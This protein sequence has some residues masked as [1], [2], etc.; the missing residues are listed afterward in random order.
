MAHMKAQ[1]KPQIIQSV[2]YET[3]WERAKLF[4]TKM[5]P[6]KSQSKPHII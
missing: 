5:F 2:S 6:Y 4:F 1:S 3:E